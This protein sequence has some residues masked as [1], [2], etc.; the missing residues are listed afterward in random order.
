MV[1]SLFEIGSNEVLVCVEIGLET[2]LSTTFFVNG[3]G[4]ALL[5]Y[6]S[7]TENIRLITLRA[8]E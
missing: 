5:A 7:E 4:T 3:F 1:V 6:V 8:G 2:T